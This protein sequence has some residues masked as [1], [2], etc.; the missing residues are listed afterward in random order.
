M[1][2]SPKRT[3]IVCRIRPARSPFTLLLRSHGDGISGWRGYGQ[4]S[5]R[6][7]LR[8]RDGCIRW[9]D[10]SRS[11][12]IHAH[13]TRLRSLCYC[14]GR[15]RSTTRLFKPILFRCKRL[16]RSATRRASLIFYP[17]CPRPPAKHRSPRSYKH[18]HH[19]R[20]SPFIYFISLTHP[21][22]HRVRR[23]VF[24]TSKRHT[25]RR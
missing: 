18:L 23:R 24:D 12:P 11:K 14:W 22:R 17:N 1:I 13:S 7:Q 6:I 3:A 4:R 15:L 10:P 2:S 9:R 20:V 8:L 21:Q 5:E 19:D 25:S 16:P